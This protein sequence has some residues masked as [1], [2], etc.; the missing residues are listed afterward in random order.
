VTE[1]G[2]T[3][4][5]TA[6]VQR[7]ITSA[8]REL[9][10]EQ[11]YE[12]TSTREI[13]QRAGV[14]QAAVFRH[15]GSKEALFEH[16][17]LAP[18]YEFV[19]QFV[20]EW[21]LDSTPEESAHNRERSYVRGMLR[22]VREN[23]VL[24]T[25]LAGAETSGQFARSGKLARSVLSRHLK[26]LEERS[27]SQ[28]ATDN[29]PTMDLSL[30]VRF[31]AALTLGFVLFEETLFPDEAS[32]PKSDELADALADYIWRATVLRPESAGPPW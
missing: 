8:A 6:D 29:R 15:F 10:V 26:D 19:D 13:A 9:F 30:A 23:R 2:R 24:F 20:T 12:K 32:R 3:R 7:L 25:M 11:G 28:V 16:V 22:L 21:A 31:G 27:R 18:L 1:N 4:R 14:I 17:V 5:T